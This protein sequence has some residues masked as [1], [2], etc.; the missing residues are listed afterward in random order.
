EHIESLKPYQA[1]KPIEEL[2]RELGLKRIIKLASNENPLGV[3]P[4]ALQAMQN[5]L[6]EL[7]RYPSPDSYYLR[8][9]L[10][11]LFKVKTNNVITGH[12]S[13]SIIS[14]IMRT[15]LH[16]EDIALTS[17][18]TFITFKIQ[19]QSRGIDLIEIPLKNYQFDLQ[20]IADQITDKTKIIYLA[21]P[22]N[23]TGSIFTDS[24]FRQFMQQVPQ[25]TLVL[26]DEAYFEFAVNNPD[27]PDSMKYR[28]DNVISLRTF[29][30][31]YGLA[32]VRIGYGFAHENLINNLMKIKLPF[33]PS[34]PAQ[35]GA[36]AALDDIDFLNQ[37]IQIA[38][39]GREFFYDFF[40]SL[41]VPY[42]ESYAN[43]VT[44]ILESENQV[45]LIYEQ[46]LKRGII[47]RPLK[48]FGLPNC[49]RI[50]TGLAEENAVF[51]ENFEQIIK[52]M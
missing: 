5:H 15:F 44:I 25:R 30:K 10:A 41:S 2:Q 46:L 38:R 21:N 45:N 47:I 27:Y 52:S 18:G 20:A 7:H 36:L 31:A 4:K 49:M 6:K 37:S 16:D 22:N 9:A 26:L 28:F 51:A 1:G 43:F 42:L 29:S 23:P 11:K 8:D 32:G 39:K 12:G 13:E 19:V 17:A 24:E 3:S 14:T 35:A 50:T 48:S 33:E 34:G 40:R